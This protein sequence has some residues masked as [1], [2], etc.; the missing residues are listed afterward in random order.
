MRIL[1]AI[2]AAAILLL[3]AFAQGAATRPQT[4]A[5]WH[6]AM[7]RIALPKKGCFSAAYPVLAWTEQACAKPVSTSYGPTVGHGTDFTAQVTGTLSSATGS[8]DG[9]NG[10]TSE[11][12]FNSVPNT[13]SLQLNSSYFKTTAA[14]AGASMPANCQGWEQF[15][16]TNSGGLLIEYWLIHYGNACPPGWTSSPP[17]CFKNSMT[18]PVPVQPLANLPNIT[19][20]GAVDA[21]GNT[22]TAT[23][24]T[25]ANMYVATGNDDVVD[26]SQAWNVAEYN[27]FGDGGGTS[28]DFNPGS[29]IT[30]RT[31]VHSGTMLAP[32]CQLQGYSDELN[33]LVLVDTPAVPVAPAPAI[34]FDETN[35]PGA[36]PGCATASGI[37]DTHLTTF[38]GLLYDFQAS[39]DFT[40]VDAGP[41]F[42]VQTRQ[43]SGAPIWPNAAVNK[44]VAARID[45]TSVA[46]CLEP[47]RLEI[48][49]APRDLADGKTLA[50]A[51]GV[52]VARTGDTYLVTG[53]NGDSLRAQLNLGWINVSV[54]L[55]SWPRPGVRGLLAN[56]NGNVNQ[57]AARDGTVLT[58]P[59]AFADLYH[60]YGDS[61]RVPAEASL[62]CKDRKVERGN[63]TTVFYARNLDPKLAAHARAI[64]AETG[65]RVPALLDACTLDV[66]VLGTPQAAKV[67]VGMKPPVAAG[68]PP[69]RN[70]LPG[71]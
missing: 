20:T 25:G 28:A 17:S 39:G 2:A 71:R 31:T 47:T 59:V 42:T 14:C 15:I 46:L 45:G 60:R 67:Y 52:S 23:L 26:L 18:M 22:D 58:E 3:P 29:T 70:G 35:I 55:G 24:W 10:V 1:R 34:V 5:E 19:V 64:C 33:N 43:A 36:L 44:D 63:P 57:L 9:V 54:G 12:G 4:Q 48:D 38:N 6:T 41:H 27:V 49:G 66:A 68:M 21:A 61:W 53:K 7:A 69:P 11:T 32:M 40:L 37:G 8:F 50:L 65:V 56:A 13:Y 16:F 30:V 51:G 62:L